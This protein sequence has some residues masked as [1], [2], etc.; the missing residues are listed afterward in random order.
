MDLTLIIEQHIVTA[1]VVTNGRIAVTIHDDA[2]I[3]IQAVKAKATVI[4]VA[5]L[6]TGCIEPGTQPT[7]Y[8]IHFFLPLVPS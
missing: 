6:H 4:L 3:L 1:Q 5:T 2:I 8:G 7:Q